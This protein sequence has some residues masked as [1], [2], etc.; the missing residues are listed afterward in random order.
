M[1]E[2]HN[3]V[4]YEQYK[5]LADACS[6]QLWLRAMLEM[7]H[8]YGWRDYS[9]LLTMRVKQI[10]LAARSI[11]LEPG[12]TKNSEGRE[13]TMTDAVYHLLAACVHGKAAN[14]H[15]FTRADGSPVKDFRGTW[16][17]VCKQAGVPDLLF[18][19]LRRTAVRNLVN[20]GVSERVAMRITGHKTRSVFDRYHIVS[21]ND[22]DNAMLKLKGSQDAQAAQA[23]AQAQ[24]GEVT[25]QNVY[26]SSTVAPQS[27]HNGPVVPSKGNA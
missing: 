8:T 18:H 14:D 24:S 2:E 26:S 19:D 27:Q 23:A 3:F 6:S 1:L 22:I 25:G 17:A 16:K 4:E 10:D 9:E 13:V 21:K 12:T 15:V 11:R 5:K 7:G 20:S